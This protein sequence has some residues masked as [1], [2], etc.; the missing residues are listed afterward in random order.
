M[1]RK[2]SRMETE[3]LLEIICKLAEG[4]KKQEARLEYYRARL[5]EV[6]GRAPFEQGRVRVLKGDGYA[7]LSGMRPEV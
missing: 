4:L 3:E 5:Q 6:S 7:D 2:G 1:S